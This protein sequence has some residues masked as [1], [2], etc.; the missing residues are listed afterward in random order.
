MSAFTDGMNQIF[1]F[2]YLSIPLNINE[3]IR[4]SPVFFGEI[5]EYLKNG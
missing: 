4:K 2:N 3:V 5:T 1:K